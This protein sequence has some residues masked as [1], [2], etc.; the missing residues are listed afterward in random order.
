MDEDAKL[1]FPDLTSSSTGASEQVL[2]D[3]SLNASPPGRSGLDI[4]PSIQVVG[5]DEDNTEMDVQH[6]QREGPGTNID[7][8]QEHDVAPQTADGSGNAIRYQG[9]QD[10]FANLDFRLDSLGTPLL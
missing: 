8:S 2:H 7:Y 1:L 3:V 9:G 10:T 4:D 5:A 6:D